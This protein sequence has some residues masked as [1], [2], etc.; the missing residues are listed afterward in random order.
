MIIGWDNG[1]KD[2][3]LKW[4]ADLEVERMA[5][6]GGVDDVQQQR[7]EEV[8]RWE[9]DDEGESHVDAEQDRTG[10]CS[11]LGGTALRWGEVRWG[12]VRSDWVRQVWGEVRQRAAEAHQVG[13]LLH[14]GGQGRGHECGGE[15]GHQTREHE[16]A[17]VQHEAWRAREEEDGGGGGVAGAPRAEQ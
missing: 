6:V 14:R 1:G 3:Q 13:L 4:V 7:G 17:E 16:C 12:G 8:E 9:G 2:M 11:E 15:A 5:G 10:R